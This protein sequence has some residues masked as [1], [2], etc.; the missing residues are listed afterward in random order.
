MDK[1]IRKPQFFAQQPNFVLEKMIQRLQNGLE[2]LNDLSGQELVVVALDDVGIP[3]PD[4]M[5]SG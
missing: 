5:T 1:I 3:A 4:S 2:L